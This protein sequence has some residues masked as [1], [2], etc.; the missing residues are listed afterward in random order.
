M[1]SF[2]S[3]RD[4]GE[5]TL[6]NIA[7]WG[8]ISWEQSKS[9]FGYLY[10]S[11]EDCRAKLLVLFLHGEMDDFVD[12]SECLAKERVEMIFNT[13]VRSG[14]KDIYRLESLLPMTAHLFPN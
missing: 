10:D 9:F 8:I 5:V 1:R 3:S 12:F 11:I 7:E 4:T 13:V 2:F 14:E 6:R